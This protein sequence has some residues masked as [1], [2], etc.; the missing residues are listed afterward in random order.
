VTFR[1]RRV[2]PLVIH[3]RSALKVDK[4]T[5]HP[6]ERPLSASEFMNVGAGHSGDLN[7]GPPLLGKGLSL[8]A[9]LRDLYTTASN[10]IPPASLPSARLPRTFKVLAAQPE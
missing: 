8:T 5:I 3:E 2:R 10:R 7:P 6:C 1:E 9:M 4:D